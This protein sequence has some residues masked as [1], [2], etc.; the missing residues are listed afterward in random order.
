[1]SHSW[2]SVLES[3]RLAVEEARDE[4][5]RLDAAAGDGDLGLTMTAAATAAAALAN[6]GE[7]DGKPSDEALRSLGMAIARSAPSTAGTLLSRGLLQASRE[8]GNGFGDQ[9][10]DVAAALVRAG[11]CGI[12]KAGKARPG[13]RTLLDALIPLAD[14]LDSSARRRDGLAAATASAAAAAKAGAESTAQMEATIG[15]ASWIP[16]R[17]RGNVDGGAYAVAVIAAAIADAFV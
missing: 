6:R 13:D 4:L 11:I 3:V 9:P 14:A 16:E 15:R 12:Q 7:L 10:V 2:C 1:V 8:A 17:A 5:G